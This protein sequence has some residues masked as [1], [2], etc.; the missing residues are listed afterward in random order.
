MGLIDFRLLI[1]LA[2]QSWTSDKIIYAIVS[3][4]MASSVDIFIGCKFI[5]SVYTDI[6]LTEITMRTLQSHWRIIVNRYAVLQYIVSGPLPSIHTYD[7]SNRKNVATHRQWTIIAIFIGNLLSSCLGGQ[8]GLYGWRNRRRLW[9]QRTDC[10]N[11]RI[12]F[13]GAGRSTS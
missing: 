10:D 1:W 12:N 8:L 2:W 7:A 13:N 4:P 11:C 5:A 6:L 9:H 3:V